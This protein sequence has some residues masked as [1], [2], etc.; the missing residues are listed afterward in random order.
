MESVGMVLTLIFYLIVGI[1]SF[2]M[3]VITYSPPSIGIIGIFS[4]VTAYGLFRKRNWTIWFVIILFLTATTLATYTLYYYF[5]QNLLFTT[6]VLAYLILT[7]VFTAYTASKR[8]TLE[9]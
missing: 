1:I 8:K 9:T 3:L 7:W 6:G 4:L 2:A 5:W